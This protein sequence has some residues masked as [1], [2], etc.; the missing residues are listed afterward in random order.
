[1]FAL[2]AYDGDFGALTPYSVTI[3]VLDGFDNPIQGAEV[4]VEENT[5]YTDI[6]GLVG[7]ENLEGDNS[8]TI[9]KTTYLD[10]EGTITHND[11]DSIITVN[12]ELIDNTAPLVSII[13]PIDGEYLGEDNI[14]VEWN[15]ADISPYTWELYLGGASNPQATGDYDD[16]HSFT[17]YPSDP[18]Y[19]ASYHG[20]VTFRVEVV[21]SQDN[22]N[23]DSISVNIETRAD[24]LPDFRGGYWCFETNNESQVIFYVKN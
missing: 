11:T 2:S 16:P 3:E 19:F 24:L 6:N 18:D 10:K 8:Y 14:T 9:N 5:K 12:L 21:D 15:I 1:M 4:T 23:N 13:S 22:S 20:L 7:F 17:F